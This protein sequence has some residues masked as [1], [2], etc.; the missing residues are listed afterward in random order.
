MN[1]YFVLKFIKRDYNRWNTLTGESKPYDFFSLPQQFIKG[2]VRKT[3]MQTV[4]Y[5]HKNSIS[6]IGDDIKLTQLCPP[7]VYH[8]RYFSDFISFI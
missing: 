3:Y 8:K 1:I 4:L 6:S 2:S 7:V 5:H